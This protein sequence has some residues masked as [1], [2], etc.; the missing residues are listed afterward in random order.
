MFYWHRMGSRRYIV[1]KYF[2]LD[3][4]DC[5]ELAI[6]EA[7]RIGVLFSD[8]LFRFARVCVCV[9]YQ[10]V[11]WHVYLEL[12]KCVRVGGVKKIFPFLGES[13]F[14]K[15]TCVDYD[16]YKK[17]E[18]FVVYGPVACG[19]KACIPPRT[20]NAVLSMSGLKRASVDS[21]VSEEDCNP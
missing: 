18:E 16:D 21:G 6:S 19:M 7:G 8:K 11:Y 17:K 5:R 14:R 13:V 1:E 2:G 4:D 3:S 10:R 20:I 12:R 15:C 9:E